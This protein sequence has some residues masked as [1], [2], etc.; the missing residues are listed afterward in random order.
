MNLREIPFTTRNPQFGDSVFR[1]SQW[2]CV[3]YYWQRGTRSSEEASLVCRNE[4]ARNIV[5]DVKS[6]L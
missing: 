1:I 2:N 5:G 3:K 4:I 6:A